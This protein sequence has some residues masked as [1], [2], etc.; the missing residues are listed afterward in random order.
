MAVRLPFPLDD[1][2]LGLRS[3]A[4]ADRELPIL[5]AAVNKR[6]DK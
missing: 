4:E 1:L 5:F 3:L 6:G 2:L